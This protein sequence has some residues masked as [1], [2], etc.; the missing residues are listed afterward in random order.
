MVIF[1]RYGERKHDGKGENEGPVGGW[2]RRD[3]LLGL[4]L[5]IRL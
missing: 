5:K 4:K 3:V 2:D 1:I